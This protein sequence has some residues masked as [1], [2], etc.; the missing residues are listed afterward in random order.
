MRNA[1]SQESGICIACGQE[2]EGRCHAESFGVIIGRE[3]RHFGACWGGRFPSDDDDMEWR[4]RHLRPK[5]ASVTP[6]PEPEIATQLA[7]L[8]EDS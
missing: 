6:P 4:T 1:L 3:G 2:P 8:E 7:L 5:P